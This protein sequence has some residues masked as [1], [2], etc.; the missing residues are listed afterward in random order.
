MGEKVYLV[1]ITYDVYEPYL[2]RVFKTHKGAKKYIKD[3]M[4]KEGWSI[5]N[6]SIAE[7]ELYE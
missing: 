1:Y 5:D 7:E 2:D 6:F 3:K 4:E